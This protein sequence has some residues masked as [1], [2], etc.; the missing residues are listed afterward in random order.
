MHIY[1]FN[2]IVAKSYLKDFC[3]TSVLSSSTSSSSSWGPQTTFYFGHNSFHT[4]IFFAMEN[5]NLNNFT[6]WCVCKC[7][8]SFEG[9]KNPLTKHRNVNG[10]WSS[11]AIRDEE[12]VPLIAFNLY[13]RVLIVSGGFLGWGWKRI[14]VQEPYGCLIRYT[15][16]HPPSLSPPSHS[17]SS[18]STFM[19]RCRPCKHILP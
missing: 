11:L 6:S 2:A 8:F 18:S 17:T 9:E 15:F 14:W 12:E 16:T 4:Y 13:N 5:P 19:T 10:R 3:I 7:N 1:R